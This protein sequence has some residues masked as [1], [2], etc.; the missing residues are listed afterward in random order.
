MWG[1]FFWLGLG[2]W[3]WFSIVYI[4]REHRLG[5]R[6]FVV[7]AVLIA[8]IGRLVSFSFEHGSPALSWLGMIVN[9]G[10]QGCLIYALLS[11]R[12]HLDSF[13]QKFQIIGLYLSVPLLIGIL[14][15]LAKWLMPPIK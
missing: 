13:T 4:T 10:L 8:L 5:W 9:A 1:F 15:R 7:W 14:N 12:M 6:E 11:L 2:A 3:L